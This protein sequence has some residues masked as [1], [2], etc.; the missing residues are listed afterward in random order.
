[1]LQYWQK[2]GGRVATTVP[3]CGHDKASYISTRH[4]YQCRRCRPQVSVTSGI[5]FHATKIPLVKWLRAIYL[6]IS[7]I[8]WQRGDF[9][10]VPFQAY[11]SLVAYGTEDVDENKNGYGLSRFNM[12]VKKFRIYSA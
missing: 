11:L 9:S 8:F 2:C 1:M 4:L 10:L 6:T 5:I 7:S 12:P 3:R